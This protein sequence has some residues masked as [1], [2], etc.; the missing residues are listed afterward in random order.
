[1]PEV[2]RGYY[3]ALDALAGP[4]VGPPL[5]LKMCSGCTRQ[6]AVEGDVGDE[7]GGC[8]WFC[9]R[10]PVPPKYQDAMVRDASRRRRP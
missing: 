2:H 4:A 10:C 6:Y 7:Q 3:P 9:W 1:M 8:P 5:A